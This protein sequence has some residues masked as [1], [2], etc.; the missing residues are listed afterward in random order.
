MK[1][2]FIESRVFT[3][4]ITALLS[5]EEFRQFQLTLAANPGAGDVIPGLG[6]LRKV[7]IAARSKGKRGGARVLYLLLP[8]SGVI[9]LIY[10]YSKGAMND[11]SHDQKRQMR[12]L[13]E[14]IKSEFQQ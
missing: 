13:A 12:R 6:G 10:V 3:E 9:Y 1:F 7:R 14:E 11:L 2:T 4:G 8:Q 5:D